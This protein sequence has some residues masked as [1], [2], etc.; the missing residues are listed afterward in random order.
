MGEKGGVID[1]D[2]RGVEDANEKRAICRRLLDGLPEWFDRP[3]AVEIY[4]SEAGELPMVAAFSGDHPLGFALLKPQTQAA[5][6]LA[7]IAIDRA[8]HRRGIGRRLV[9]T[10][11]QLA[12]KRGA[13]FLTVKSVDASFPNAEYDATREFYR[14]MGFEP[15]E[16]FPDLWGGH[17]PC[18]LMIRVIA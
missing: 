17:V 2:I 6:E 14:T 8:F 13:R 9:T 4:I 18:L 1:L 16:V 15:L 10:M 12:R 11:D 5:C 3:E 7:L